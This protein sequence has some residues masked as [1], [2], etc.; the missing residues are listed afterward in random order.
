MP[1]IFDVTANENA[2][3]KR[4]EL[5]LMINEWKM[6][7]TKS[8]FLHIKYLQVY[9]ININNERI[10]IKLDK[11]FIFIKNNITTINS[12]KAKYWM[13]V[14]VKWKSFKKFFTMI[15]NLIGQQ[16]TWTENEKH[17]NHKKLLFETIYWK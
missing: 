8:I 6:L 11:I 2:R 12:I 10:L 16:W 3:Y 5:A 15:I 9:I 14:D 1:Q 17:K 13:H 4:N 7:H